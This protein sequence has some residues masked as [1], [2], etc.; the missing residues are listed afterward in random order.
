MLRIIRD[1]GEEKEHYTFLQV[2]LIMAIMLFMALPVGK[3]RSIKQSV[4][5]NFNQKEYSYKNFYLQVE[6]RFL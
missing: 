6:T 3:D 4:F 5:G 1:N 2:V